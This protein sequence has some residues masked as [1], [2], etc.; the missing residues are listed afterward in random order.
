M[1]DISDKENAFGSRNQRRNYRSF[2]VEHSKCSFD[3]Q[4][5][6]GELIS[7]LRVKQSAE[8]EKGMAYLEN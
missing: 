8:A 7:R 4:R 6:G 1:L 5:L 3:R 2:D